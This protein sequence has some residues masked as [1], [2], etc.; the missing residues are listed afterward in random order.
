MK[1]GPAATCRVGT[2]ISLEQGNIS[3]VEGDLLLLVILIFVSLPRAILSLARHRART[4]LQHK[5]G[6]R[7]VPAKANFCSLKPNCFGFGFKKLK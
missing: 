6:R 7:F 3:G 4:A 5:E 1:E 2:Y